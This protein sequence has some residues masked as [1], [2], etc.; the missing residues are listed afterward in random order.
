MPPNNSISSDK[1]TAAQAA[2]L[3]NRISKQLKHLGT[4][5]RRNQIFAFR[6]YDKDIPEIPLSIDLY[7]EKTTAKKYLLVALYERPYEKD[8]AEEESW[9]N[10]MCRALAQVVAIPEEHIFSKFRSRKKGVEA[11]Y[12]KVAS[13][14]ERIKVVEGGSTFLVNLQDYLDSG[15]FL[16][17]RPTRL[18]IQTIAKDKDILN[19][20]C[21]TGAFSVH[22]AQGGARSVCSVDLSKT[23]LAWAQDN[24]V[25]NGFTDSDKY[26]FVHKDVKF[27]L[28]DAFNMKQSWDLIVCDPPT[29]SNSKRSIETL[30]INRDY[31]ELIDACLK[32]LRPKGILFFSTNSRTLKFDQNLLE[33]IWLDALTIQ[34]ETTQSIPKDFRNQKIHR[35]WKISKK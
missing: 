11:Q 3:V 8:S 18:L 22:A 26:R 12:E 6:L 4:W 31:I 25:E 17:H 20:F 29:F 30:D 10:E 14:G 34:D 9:L 32:V 15:L 23:Y 7:I 13:F 21:Y 16:D 19:L 5:A 2:M 33:S 35:L 24:F 28:K 1:K 27:F